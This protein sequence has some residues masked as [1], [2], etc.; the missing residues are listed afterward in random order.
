MI[1]ISKD[2]E[3]TVLLYTNFEVKANH[4]F[5]KG[6]L[7]PAAISKVVADVAKIAK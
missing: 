5:R 4:T 7:N 3:V 1:T 2:A 6:E